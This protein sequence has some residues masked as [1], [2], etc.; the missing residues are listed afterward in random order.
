MKD[1]GRWRFWRSEIEAH[2]RA[3]A[4]LPELPIDP[5]KPDFLVD[6][7]TVSAEFGFNR[8]TLGRRVKEAV[9]AANEAALE[10][11]ADAA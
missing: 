9:D 6:A 11:G 5:D 2:K 8:R 10:A 1:R 4:G 3:L 7:K